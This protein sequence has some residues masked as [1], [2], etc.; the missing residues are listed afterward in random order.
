MNQK[1]VALVLGSF[2][3]LIH[4]V[5]GVL[6]AVGFAQPL[7]NFILMMHSLNNPFTVAPF[8]LAR[9]LG[10]VVVTFIVGYVVGYVFAA[11][12]NKFHR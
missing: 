4:L 3:G 10:L 11:L 12:W 8:N 5:W 9:S 6:I 1:K 7:L 2:I